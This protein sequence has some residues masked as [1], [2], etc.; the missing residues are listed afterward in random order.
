MADQFSFD[1][2]SE[3]DL[4]E[5]DNAIN[6]VKK[7]MSQR[8]DFKN[9]K[10]SVEFNRNDKKITIN[11][12]DDYKLKSIKEM[13]SEKFAKRGISPK[14][15][16]YGKEEKAFEGTIRLV[17]DITTGIPKEKAKELAQIIKDMKLKVQA[18]IQ[19][20]KVRVFSS[21]KDDLQ[22]VIQKV[23]SLDF[24]VPLQFN[25]YR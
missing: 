6:Q 2:V 7:E 15:L 16:N 13:L 25:N 24:A 5:V 8:Y 23:R 3:V 18:Q 17:A 20:D 12:D 9:S 21:K 1:I 22:S 4:Q 19:E 11:S 10:S 14:S